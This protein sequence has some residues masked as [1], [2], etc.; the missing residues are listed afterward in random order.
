V[1]D[2]VQILP[3]TVTAKVRG[4]QVHNCAVNSAEAGQ[5]TAINLQGLERT[6]IQRGQVLVHPDTMTATLRI[7]TFL[8]YLPPDKR[9]IKHRSLVRLHTGTS[10]TMARVLLM[11]REELQPGEKTYAQF[12]TEEPVVVMAGDHFVIRSYSPI[13]TLGG[14]LIIDPLSRKLQR[15][16]ETIME[17]FERLHHGSEEEKISAIIERAGPEGIPL[18]LLVMRTGLPSARL[19]K[20]LDGLISRHLL[21]VLDKENLTVVSASFHQGLQKQ[22]L[23]ELKAYHKKYPL[24]EGPLKEE[25]RSALG[26]HVPVRL[27][28]SAVQSLARTEK[29]ALEREI[30]RLAEHQI[31][32]QEDLAEL[33]EDLNRL[34]LESGLTPPTMREV[35]E[36][37]A[38]KKETAR[39]VMDVML[40]EGILVKISEDLYFHRDSLQNL[41]ENYKNLLIKEGKATPSNFRELTGLSRK[42]IIPLMEYFDL[43]KLTIRA[44]EHLLLR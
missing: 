26:R 31:N 27:F 24:K 33:R 11:D 13:T 25:L 1:A 37:F 42:F 22:I 8:E 40:R 39:K 36:R 16:D 14:G 34:Y 21:I 35:M 38:S 23:Q 5:R 28:L 9:K 43:T 3:G 19:K 20:V 7:D 10:E 2:T 15:H 17:S 18:A 29:I 12:L 41:R 30:I 32:L 6:D 4:I 44:G